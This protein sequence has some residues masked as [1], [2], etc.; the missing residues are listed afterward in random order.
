MAYI[1]SRQA[2]G[3][4]TIRGPTAEGVVVD[5]TQRSQFAELTLN[6]ESQDFHKKND[7]WLGQCTLYFQCQKF[8]ESGARCGGICL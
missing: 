8:K 4:S 3:V 6:K 5:V 7:T 2:W 1:D